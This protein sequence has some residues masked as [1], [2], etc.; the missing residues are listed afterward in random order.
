MESN[1]NGDCIAVEDVEVEGMVVGWIGVVCTNWVASVGVVEA[2]DL[3]LWY[4]ERKLKLAN[5][6]T[7]AENNNKTMRERER[8]REVFVKILLCIQCDKLNYTLT[9]ISYI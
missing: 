4:H 7:M 6:T 8:E 5:F 2:M 3:W 1:N 9:H